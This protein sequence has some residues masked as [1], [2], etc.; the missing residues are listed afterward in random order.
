MR[1]KRRVREQE[2]EQE[3]EHVQVNTHEF[4]YA[5]DH[6]HVLV[7]LNFT[8]AVSFIKGSHSPPFPHSDCLLF[9]LFNVFVSIT[10][11]V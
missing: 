1:G 10:F 5:D 8:V 2:Q 9:L 4:D 6:A 11:E 3:H 7:G